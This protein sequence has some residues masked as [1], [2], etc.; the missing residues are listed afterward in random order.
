MK[1]AYLV[2]VIGLA[3]MATAGG[4]FVLMPNGTGSCVVNGQ[5][6][7]CGSGTMQC[8]VN[9]QIVPCSS[10]GN[11]PPGAEQQAGPSLVLDPVTLAVVGLLV[12]IAGAAWLIVLRRQRSS[13]KVTE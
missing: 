12:T 5:S 4:I 6:V 2:I 10:A 7:P 9:G 8:N 3:L 1:Y 13:A 11:P